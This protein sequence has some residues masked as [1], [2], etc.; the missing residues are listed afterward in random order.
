MEALDRHG[1]SG[2]KGHTLVVELEIWFVV[3][4]NLQR[5][6]NTLHRLWNMWGQDPINQCERGQEDI[7]LEM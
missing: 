6:R 3:A 1:E 5:A 2:G 7:G 4:C